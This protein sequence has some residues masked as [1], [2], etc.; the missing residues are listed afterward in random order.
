VRE[1]PIKPEN[2]AKYPKDWPAIRARILDRAKHKCEWCG[3]ANYAIGQRDSKGSF[4]EMGMME[5]EA[6][7]LDGERVVK[8]VLTIAHVHDPDPSNCADENL[9]ALCQ[10]CHNLHDGPMRRSNAAAT[11]DAKKGP[12]L[13]QMPA[14]PTGVK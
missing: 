13:F 1:V 9:A 12:M 11:R 5:A 6:A 4:R 8:I 2:K 14:A 10:R 3:V 7:H